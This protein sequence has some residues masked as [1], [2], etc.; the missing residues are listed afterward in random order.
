MIKPIVFNMFRPPNEDLQLLTSALFDALGSQA[1]HLKVGPRRRRPRLNQSRVHQQRLPWPNLRHRPRA[2]S[3][4]SFSCHLHLS[5]QDS[6]T[7]PLLAGFSASP[8]DEHRTRQQ[9][10]C[11][12][13]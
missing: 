7:A 11:A 2:S 6:A 5:N 13:R 9:S 12:S 1:T 3:I 10:H 8:D 4:Q